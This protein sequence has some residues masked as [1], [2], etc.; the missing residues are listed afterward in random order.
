MMNCV[1]WLFGFILFK[2]AGQTIVF[3]NQVK[4]VR[5][6]ETC[7]ATTKKAYTKPTVKAVKIDKAV[8]VAASRSGM[9]NCKI[10]YIS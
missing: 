10:T 2:Q 6:E 4:K 7:M 5:K 9:G 8:M 3:Y 1:R